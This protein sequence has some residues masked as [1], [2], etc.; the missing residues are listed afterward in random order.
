MI[1]QTISKQFNYR[2][3][4]KARVRK[5][6]AKEKSATVENGAAIVFYPRAWNEREWEH[7]CEP[8]EW[9]TLW[10]E[11]RPMP[12]S[13]ARLV[14]QPLSIEQTWS[15]KQK[16]N[17][18]RARRLRSRHFT[19]FIYRPSWRSRAIFDNMLRKWMIPSGWSWTFSCETRRTSMLG[20]VLWFHYPRRS[21][22]NLSANL[23]SRCDF[24][25]HFLFFE[26]HTVI[27]SLTLLMY[28]P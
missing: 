17:E 26:R 23:Q 12:V 11:S 3:V 16:N 9:T 18:N 6:R 25:R 13:A 28:I 2:A 4:G 20:F 8:G 22:W 1:L 24:Y 7:E 27:F 19:R 10:R 5:R 15:W 14:S 21:A